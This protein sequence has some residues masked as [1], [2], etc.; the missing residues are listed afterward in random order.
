MV[1]QFE[2]PK[3]RR[4]RKRMLDKPARGFEKEFIERNAT[5]NVTGEV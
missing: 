4:F 2:Q 3:S 1:G 5:A